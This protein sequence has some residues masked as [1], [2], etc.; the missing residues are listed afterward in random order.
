MK[1]PECG[2]EPALV[3]FCSIQKHKVLQ[4]KSLKWTEKNSGKRTV[5][6]HVDLEALLQAAM[7]APVTPGFVDD[8]ILFS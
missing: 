6:V 3:K 5:F 1:L 2:S 8:A 4:L 7:W